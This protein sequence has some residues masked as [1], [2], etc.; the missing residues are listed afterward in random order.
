MASLSD[1]MYATNALQMRGDVNQPLKMPIMSAA[2]A[3]MA[4]CPTPEGMET[5]SVWSSWKTGG[6]DRVPANYPCAMEQQCGGGSE[7]GRSLVLRENSIWGDVTGSADGSGYVTTNWLPPAVPAA[8]LG[9]C[10]ISRRVV[11]VMS[12]DTND[13]GEAVKTVNNQLYLC[14]KQY[15]E[16]SVSQ[17]FLDGKPLLHYWTGRPFL[18][19]TEQTPFLYM[20]PNAIMVKTGGSKYRVD[21]IS[22]DQR[23]QGCC[24]GIT[25]ANGCADCLGY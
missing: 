17:L 24:S 10:W 18:F 25:S 2:G 9:F 11:P 13:T 4:T 21:V 22:V 15:A 23:G 16:G 3:N 1:A 8:R 20:V 19:K 12:L 5:P 14:D 7:C 6:S